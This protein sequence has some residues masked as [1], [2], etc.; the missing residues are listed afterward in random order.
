MIFD[1]LVDDMAA[2]GEI[3]D[4]IGSTA[5]WRLKG[6]FADIALLAVLVDIFPPFPW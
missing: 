5:E 4:A 6:G 1:A 3:P 2:G